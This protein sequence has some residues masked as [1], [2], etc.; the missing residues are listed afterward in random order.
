MPWAPLPP[1][2]EGEDFKDMIEDVLEG[3]DDAQEANNQ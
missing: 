1:E 3:D 2:D